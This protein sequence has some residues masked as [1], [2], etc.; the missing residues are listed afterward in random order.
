MQGRGACRA[1]GTSACGCW[2]H[3]GDKQRVNQAG[4]AGQYE[5]A[6]DREGHEVGA[7]VRNDRRRELD[8]S[9]PRHAGGRAA[10]GSGRWRIGMRGSAGVPAVSTFEY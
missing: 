3:L 10:S 1:C 6:N 8:R 4:Q 9:L 7:V 2:P 5:A